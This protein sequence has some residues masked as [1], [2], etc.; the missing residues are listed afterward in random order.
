MISQKLMEKE[1]TTTIYNGGCSVPVIKS[2]VV[3]FL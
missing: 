1:E 3:A 2:G